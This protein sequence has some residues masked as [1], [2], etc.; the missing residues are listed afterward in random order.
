MPRD[1]VSAYVV[2]SDDDGAYTGTIFTPDGSVSREDT[3][4]TVL[5]GWI[6]RWARGRGRPLNINVDLGHHPEAVPR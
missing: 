5:V 6:D 1:N 3:D 2:W 4:P